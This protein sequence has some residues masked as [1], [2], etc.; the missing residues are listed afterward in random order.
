MIMI[1]FRAA[2]YP[3]VEAADQLEGKDNAKKNDAL[4]EDSEK[5]KGEGLNTQA[6]ET[7]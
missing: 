6:G 2:L 1:M 4:G 3:V 7:E 5:V